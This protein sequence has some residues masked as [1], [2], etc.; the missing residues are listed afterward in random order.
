M[1][2]RALVASQLRGRNYKCSRVDDRLALQK[3]TVAMIEN[4][5]TPNWADSKH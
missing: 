5:Q 3:S 4:A 1:W 2:G